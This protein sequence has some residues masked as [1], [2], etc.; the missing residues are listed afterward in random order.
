[1]TKSQKMLFEHQQQLLE[2]ACDLLHEEVEKPMDPFLDPNI[3]DRSPFHL[4]KSN[5]MNLANV[6]RVNYK[7]FIEALN[8]LDIAF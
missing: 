7:T 1:M 2:E 5:L 3:P 6:T 8:D 4:Y